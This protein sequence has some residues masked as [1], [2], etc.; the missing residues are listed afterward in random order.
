[1][2]SSGI[3]GEAMAASGVLD[4]AVSSLYPKKPEERWDA[5]GEGC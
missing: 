2:R 4:G 1:M 3:K 5:C